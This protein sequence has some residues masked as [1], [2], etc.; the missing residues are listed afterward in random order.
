[1]K[2][3]TLQQY[4][5]R[6]RRLILEIKKETVPVAGMI[7]FIKES[8]REGKTVEMTVTGSSMLPLLKDRISCV[9]LARPDSLSKGDIVLFERS[10]GQYVLH[11]I[12]SVRGGMFDI[13]GDN[14]TSADRNVPFVKILAKVVRYAKD[15]RHWKNSD[16][17]YR[18]FL[19]A[20]KKSGTIP[21]GSKENFS[22]NRY[23]FQEAPGLSA[24]CRP[25][26]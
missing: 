23:F 24:I 8:L 6:A 22:E 3:N 26:K 14:R 4:L 25:R 21:A 16:R 7:P 11:R 15:G 1:M 17:L 19:P 5:N 12:S 9:C 2:K 20:I 18:M 10:D 13:V